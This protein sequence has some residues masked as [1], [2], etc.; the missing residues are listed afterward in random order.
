MDEIYGQSL[1]LM[2]C[3]EGGNEDVCVA[4]FL[5]EGRR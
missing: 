3:P 4:V 1:V 5:V 2:Y